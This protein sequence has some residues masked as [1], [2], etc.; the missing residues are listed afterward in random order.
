M[1]K[2]PN[3][4][5]QNS[6][7][8]YRGLK[9]AIEK[10]NGIRPSVKWLNDNGFSTI[11]NVASRYYGGIGLELD[12]LIEKSGLKSWGYWQDR[13]NF[14]RELRDAIEVNHGVRPTQ[15]W[16]A[17]NGYSG[18][19]N[20]ANKYYGG[21]TAELDSLIGSVSRKFKGYWQD[22]SNFDR[23]LKKA[24]ESNGGERPTGR[25]LNQNGHGGLVA[26]SKRNYGITI[27]ES[28]DEYFENKNDSD[29]L[30]SMLEDYVSGGEM[31]G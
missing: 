16:L 19:V 25:W 6:E 14:D 8:F 15:R 18:I 7:N 27:G 5:W 20:A 24:I 2:K 28:M 13:S 31:D 3:G 4:Y 12:R 11:A 30:R 21:L 10:N 29:K 1:G 22:R 23:E 17:N 26:A 9:S